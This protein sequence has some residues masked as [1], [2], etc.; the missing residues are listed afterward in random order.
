[1]EI[2]KGIVQVAVVVSTSGVLM[3]VYAIKQIRENRF[4][5]FL[6]IIVTIIALSCYISLVRR[7]IL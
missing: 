4:L 7:G 5:R 6:L 2:W 1:M 3:A